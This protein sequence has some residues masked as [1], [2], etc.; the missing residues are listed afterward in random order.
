ME[1][2]SG[3]LDRLPNLIKEKEMPKEEKLHSMMR[4]VGQQKCR[5]H[6]VMISYPKSWQLARVQG[7][8]GSEAMHSSL[9]RY[10]GGCHVWMHSSC[11]HVM[12][13]GLH[14]IHRS[15]VHPA[16]LYH[17]MNSSF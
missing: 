7:V 4:E 2:A 11:Q 16:L 1:A 15:T 14:A 8:H 3:V 5:H 17:C 12:S 13:K 6:L 9:H 10:Q